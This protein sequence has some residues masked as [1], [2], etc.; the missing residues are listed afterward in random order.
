MAPQ[1]YG[2]AVYGELLFSERHRLVIGFDASTETSDELADP[3]LDNLRAGH[4]SLLNPMPSRY[5]WV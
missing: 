2:P 1:D 5:H 4:E 3:L